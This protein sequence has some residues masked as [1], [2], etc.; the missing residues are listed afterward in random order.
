M[1]GLATPGAGK[2]GT[3]TVGGA[4]G[5]LGVVAVLGSTAGGAE[6]A[7]ASVRVAGAAGVFVVAA[8]GATT[9]VPRPPRTGTGLCGDV[10]DGFAG[11]SACAGAKGANNRTTK[12]E[13]I[14][15]TGAFFWFTVFFHW[16][17]PVSTEQPVWPRVTQLSCPPVFSGN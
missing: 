1:A 14:V 7:T 4:N 5:R 3:P 6:G 12:R 2:L 10:A 15:F 9:L 8:D 17:R 16:G 11:T 13:K